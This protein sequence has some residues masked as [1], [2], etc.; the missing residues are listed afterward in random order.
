VEVV[1]RLF[2]LQ[3]VQKEIE[4]LTHKMQ[5]IDSEVE[6]YRQ[7]WTDAKKGLQAEESSLKKLREQ[8]F[9]EELDL[10][11]IEEHIGVLKERL[12]SGRGKSK[13]LA[14]MQRKVENLSKK[15]DEKETIV[16]ELMDKLSSAEESFAKLSKDVHLRMDS[17]MRNI[18]EA[19]L[20]RKEIEQEM[21]G[22]HLK[23][24]DIEAEIGREYLYLYNELRKLLKYPVAVVKDGVC[25][26]CSI[27]LPSDTIK[28]LKENRD[29]VRCDSCGRILIMEGEI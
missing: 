18:E 5:R 7:R 1:K 4:K 19:L 25:T 22:L 17:L 26:G 20:K 16:L 11:E 29:I 6:G 10:K 28:K 9:S 21:E 27:S 8:L 14:G 15:K 23:E 13:E 12:Y 24:R 3:T 2:E